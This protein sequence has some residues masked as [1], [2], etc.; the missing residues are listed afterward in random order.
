[1]P[2]P[3]VTTDWLEEHLHDDDL[4]V[5]EIR[6]KVLPPSQPPPHY[7]S[8]REAYE[9]AHI[10]GAIYVDWQVD[11]V[12]PGSPSNDIASPERFAALMES[13]GISNASTIVLSD[14]AAGM[15]ACRM[16]W[17]LRHY[18]HD[19]ACV[20]DGGW[21][22]WLAEGRPSSSAV[23]RH[24]RGDFIVTVNP[25]LKASLPEILR[26]LESQSM[27]LVD[28]RSPAEF[29]GQNS[30]ARHGGHIPGALN[31]PRSLL[32]ADDMTMK[33]DVELRAIFADMGIDLEAP[34]TVLYCNSGVSATYGMLA[35]ERAG[36]KNLRI[37]DGS[38]KEWGNDDATPKAL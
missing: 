20:L 25:A 24:P 9:S 27:Q 17:A 16:L 28:V 29:T 12:E 31:L 7:F 15:F 30:R 23:T 5:I 8:D 2:G 14:D 32:L 35:M 22:K 26:G 34:D 1:M 11:I 33:P 10:P 19:K 4:R 18:G 13:L 21:T 6:G 36:A 38:W 3:L 37:Y